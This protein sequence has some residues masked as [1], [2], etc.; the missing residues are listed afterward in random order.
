MAE[1]DGKVA[2]ITGGASGIGRASARRFARAGARVAVVDI[3]ADAVDAVCAELGPDAALGVRADVTDETAMQTAVART[4]ERFGRLDTGLFCAGVA[5]AAPVHLLPAPDFDRV[6]KVN[7]YGV[8]YAVKHCAARLI[9]QGTGGSLTAI[10]SLNARQAAEGLTAYTTSKAAVAMLMQNTALELGRYGIRA[11]AIG[12]G[13]VATPLSERLWQTDALRE[14]FL[15]ETPLGRYAEPEE[16]AE[17]AL[18]LAS[19]AA[20][21]LTGQTVY[22]DGGTSLKKYPELFRFMP[23]PAGG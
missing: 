15:A 16:V 23:P 19:D 2:L 21:Y 9:E 22:L 5:A 11:N 18:F 17:L 4:V 8:F 14:A 7:V 6:L 1:L 20:A 13:L 12:P 10:A 3:T